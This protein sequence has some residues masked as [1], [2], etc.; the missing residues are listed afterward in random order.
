MKIFVIGGTG[1][2]G[3]PVVRA[4]QAAGHAVRIFSRAPQQARARLG[5]D[6][7]KRFAFILKE[8]SNV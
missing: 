5:T 7:E 1:M 6:V 3:A 4:L 8:K 2:L